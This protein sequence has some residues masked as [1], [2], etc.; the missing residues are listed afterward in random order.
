MNFREVWSLERYIDLTAL[1]YA[2]QNKN[3]VAVDILLKHGADIE[4]KADR[5]QTPLSLAVSSRQPRNATGE[6]KVAMARILLSNGANIEAMDDHQCSPLSWAVRDA[7]DDRIVRYLV[8]EGASVNTK[9]AKG[10]SV[11]SWAVKNAHRNQMSTIDI[12]F[13]NG[14]EI[15]SA[16]NAG[17]TA[18]VWAVRNH[19]SKAAEA[20]LKHGARTEARASDGDTALLMAASTTSDGKMARLLLRFSAA[21]DQTDAHGLT[22]LLTSPLFSEAG[23]LRALVEGKANLEAK[24]PSNDHTTLIRC[25]ASFQ[26]VGPFARISWGRALSSR[27]STTQAKLPCSTRQLMINTRRYRDF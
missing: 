11:L 5:G 13:E 27:A 24:D 2:A 26:G 7:E 18:L 20:R 21:I 6:T 3:A 19:A 15:N 4:A 14:A 8:Q 23:S 25:A 9:D 16:D 12:M 17:R 10:R 1:L 22:S